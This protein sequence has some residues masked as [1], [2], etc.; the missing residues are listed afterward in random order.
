MLVRRLPAIALLAALPIAL[1]NCG[2][3]TTNG[4]GGAGSPAAGSPGAAG[5]PST[6]A[7][8]PS[9]AGSPTAVAGGGSTSVAG[10]GST[11]VAGGGSTSVGGTTSAGGSSGGTTG[12]AGASAA[13]AGGGAAG[14]STTGFSL[15]SPNHMEGAKF[16][17]KYTCNGGS[18]GGG[19]I[20][21]LDWTG[22]PS[23]TMSFAI[24]FIDTTIGDDKQMGQHWAIWNIPAT[25]TKIP[26]GT[27]TL[28]GDLA[29]A[30]QSGTYLSPCAQ[31]LMNGMDDQYEFTIYALPTATLN[32]TGTSVANALMALKAL[33]PK[34]PTATLHG[35]AGLKGK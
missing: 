7:G 4:G 21:E 24:T 11:S 34:P 30:K 18:L 26:E 28:S 6:S 3:D 32:V 13:G 5:S 25:V 19:V 15:T 16:D 35:H 12:A 17:G 20:P 31:S 14:G 27:K 22:V 29:M 1:A 33:S 9:A 2:S 23:G 10:G 8:S